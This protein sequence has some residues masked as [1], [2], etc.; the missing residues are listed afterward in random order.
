MSAAHAEAGRELPR[1]LRARGGFAGASRRRPPSGSRARRKRCGG[2]L[3]GRRARVSSASGLRVEIVSPER[4]RPGLR[5][6]DGRGP[7]RGEQ[8][9]GGLEHALERPVAEVREIVVAG[10][11]SASCDPTRRLV[12]GEV[13][14]R[15]GQ[16]EPEA[17]AG[18]EQRRRAVREEPLEVSVAV[19]RRA[20]GGVEPSEI[21]GRGL[22]GPRRV[23]DPRRVA[24]HR[25][26]AAA[27][28][29]EHLRE[30]D[31]PVERQVPLPGSVE[32]WS[33]ALEPN[34]FASMEVSGVAELLQASRRCAPRRSAREPGPRGSPRAAACGPGTPT[35]P[36]PGG[37]LRQRRAA[38]GRGGRR[39]LP[40][41][42]GRRRR[43]SARRPGGG[44]R[45]GAGSGSPGAGP[46]RGEVIGE[47]AAGLDEEG[48]RAHGRIAD[49]EPE[50][51]A[52]G[53]AVH[54]EGREGPRHHDLRDR[55]P[56]VVGPCPDGD[57]SPGWRK[58]DPGA[59]GLGLSRRHARPE[60]GE[61][62]VAAPRLPHGFGSPP[63]QLHARHCGKGAD[64]RRPVERRQRIQ[65][66]DGV[67]GQEGDAPTLRR[68]HPR[69]PGG[70]R[71]PP[72][73]ARRRAPRH[74]P[75]GADRA[76]GGPRRPRSPRCPPGTGRRPDRG[77]GVGRSRHPGSTGTPPRPGPTPP[78]APPARA[79]RARHRA[80]ENS[81]EPRSTSRPLRW[82]GARD[83][84]RI[85]R[86]PSARGP[87]PGRGRRGAPGP[88]GAGRP[89]G[90]P[91]PGPRGA[92]R[93]APPA[94]GPGARSRPPHRPPR[95]RPRPS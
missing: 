48:A 61:E 15:G 75:R 43:G 51:L 34:L 55:P 44:A 18:S 35:G 2:S 21:A 67:V 3:G 63:P 39:P 16:H 28:L 74:P 86:R 54:E 79:R 14:H 88:R 49:L 56:G 78:R 32:S 30:L 23:G 24:D 41:G 83:P 42:P 5:E 4:P 10:R 73:G 12:A 37:R 45:A 62:L 11:H 20:G 38:R 9:H 57:P 7:P 91:R 22:H 50:D 92:A 6:R 84:R 89:R 66:D 77:S 71:R 26:E 36:G 68:P 95:A 25:V 85:A 80:C 90:D 72:R 31:L 60:R 52:G 93:A 58:R 19:E 94:P 81:V 70:P 46:G 47:L 53:R 69:T 40:G 82:A 1:A 76:P 13:G 87:R 27:A 17:P 64:A 65:V 29:R 8:A 59:S 33:A